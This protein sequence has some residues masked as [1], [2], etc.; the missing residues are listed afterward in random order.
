[1]SA[2]SSNIDQLLYNYFGGRMV[3]DV[4]LAVDYTADEG[5][6]EVHSRSG[7]LRL[8]IT[9]SYYP[10]GLYALSTNYANGLGIEKV[11][12]EEVNPQLRGGKVENHLGK[13][14]PSYPTETRTSISPSSAVELNTTSALANYATEADG[15]TVRTEQCSLD[16]S[17]APV[18]FGSVKEEDCFRGNTPALACKEADKPLGMNLMAKPILERCCV[19]YSS[20]A[21]SPSF[22]SLASYTVWPQA[23]A[24]LTITWRGPSSML[25][26]LRHGK[27]SAQW[28]QHPDRVRSMVGEV[29]GLTALLSSNKISDPLPRHPVPLDWNRNQPAL[30]LFEASGRSDD[31]Q[32]DPPSLCSLCRWYSNI[33]ATGQRRAEE[34][35]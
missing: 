3:Y 13:T 25:G 29:G 14:T 33:P 32:I 26:W 6:I 5:E 16:D 18:R 10:F 28:D 24:C 2:Y 9:A 1:M 22:A 34:V 17:S 7:V 15:Y 11:E 19:T 21:P 30:F 23:L 35:D 20:T 12:L 8:K 27:F 4:T 31:R